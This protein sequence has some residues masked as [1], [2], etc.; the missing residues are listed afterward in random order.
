MSRSE[1][2]K[3]AYDSGALKRSRYEKYFQRSVFDIEYIDSIIRSHM[4]YAEDRVVL[5]LGSNAWIGYLHLKNIR[6]KKLYC[7]NISQKEL[8]IGIRYKKNNSIAFP[9]EFFLMDATRPSF[10]PSQFDLI[11]G[12]AI[13]HHLDIG[14]T[15]RNIQSLLN[16]NGRIFFHEPLGANPIAKIIRFFTPSARTKDERPLT[17][18][19]I[20]YI[21]NIF[22]CTNYV[23]GGMSVA[24]AVITNL[25]ANRTDTFMDKFSGRIDMLVSHAHFLHP[26]FRE[27]LISGIKRCK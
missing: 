2:E 9:I 5:E 10:N 1:R 14:M 19:D 15:I 7:I 13:L 26:L 18:K 12:G 8:D 20:V 16:N 11:F 21:N 17:R 3:H 22:T 25:L 27:I 6:P 24:T 4:S 23:L